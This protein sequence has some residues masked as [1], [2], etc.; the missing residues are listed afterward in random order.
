MQIDKTS[1]Q[2]LSVFHPDE[3]QSVFHFLNRTQTNEGRAYLQ[4]W[5]GH[6]PARLQQVKQIQAQLQFLGSIAAAWP[7]QPTNGSF[8]VLDKFFETYVEAYPQPVNAFSAL[9]YTLLHPADHSLTRFS[10]KHTMDLVK[11]FDEIARLLENAPTETGFPAV[12]QRIHHL[13]KADWIREMVHASVEQ[14]TNVEW[15][16]WGKQIKTHFKQS[17][18]EL[19]QLY[20]QLDAQ[21]AVA[22]GG[23]ERGFHFPQWAESAQPHVSIQGLYHCLLKDPVT[24]DVHLG[25][26]SNFMFLT[27]ANMGGKSTFIRSFGLAVYLAHLG[28]PV[29]A[30]Q[31]KGSFLHGLISNIQVSDN[32]VQGES[33]FFN[34][35][36]RIKKTVE[37]V[38]D[39]QAWLVLIDELFKGTNQEDAVRCSTE[40]I[41]GLRKCQQSLFVL[42]THLYEIGPPLAQYPNVQFRYFETALQSG[43]LQFTY[44]LK[45]GISQDRLGYLILE[46]EGVVKL[47]NE[48]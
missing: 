31:Y 48:L 6:P 4:W 25:P 40:V 29:P 10:V 47:L 22:K 1:L 24:Y 15:L 33:F 43:Q 27:G 30:Q 46:R 7:L 18:E 2:D 21:M 41:K 44:R 9:L 36:Q 20:G 39:G 11:G 23:L 37:Q 34:E 13:L 32:L 19:T 12:G 3:E 45:E 16:Y 17:A 38:S 42:S 28:M 8:L 14:V 5:L 26:G 35:V